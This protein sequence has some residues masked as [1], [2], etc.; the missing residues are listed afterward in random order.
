[1]STSSGESSGAP[2]PEQKQVLDSLAV[3]E[4]FRVARLAD[5]VDIR[6]ARDL[7]LKRQR[8]ALVATRGDADPRVQA[9][10]VRIAVNRSALAI[11][12]TEA[13]R[14]RTPTPTAA[15]N[16]W[17][18]YGFV[19]GENGT[20]LAGLTVTLYIGRRRV[21]GLDCSASDADGRY[22][23]RVPLGGKEATGVTV[24]AAGAKAAA[25]NVSVRVLDAKE[26]C[27]YEHPDPVSVS[28]G[29][30]TYLEMTVPAPAP[31]G[32]RGGRSKG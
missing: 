26:K 22:L 3:V 4:E 20:G 12:S 7:V 14:A 32:K 2:P 11:L 18:L 6:N 31:T 28:P 8:A 30:V 25:A 27:L 24:D 13:A 15:A 21:K 1:M 17:V 16:E 10:D 9:L 23:L 19:R 5:M 29:T